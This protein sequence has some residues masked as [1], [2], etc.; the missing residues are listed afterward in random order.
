M[1]CESSFA[2]IVHR[3]YHAQYIINGHLKKTK[4]LLILPQ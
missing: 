3:V 4:I 2:E 1:L